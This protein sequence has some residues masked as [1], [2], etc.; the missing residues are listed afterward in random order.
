[1]Y[2]LGAITL[3][4][5]AYIGTLLYF[6]GGFQRK[7]I[8]FEIKTLI[9]A[10]EPTLL[11]TWLPFIGHAFAF[12]KRP[13]EFMR[14]NFAK[15]GNIFGFLMGGKRT[16][17]VG[18]AQSLLNVYKMK[19]MSFESHAARSITCCFGASPASHKYHDYQMTR[20]VNQKHMLGMLLCI[21]YCLINL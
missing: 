3:L 17:A 20:R 1:M 9:A 12:S 16:F 8:C 14:E 4:A 15:H 13:Y 18:D 7:S 6:R 19:E 10:D 2:F 11:W 21:A 5:V